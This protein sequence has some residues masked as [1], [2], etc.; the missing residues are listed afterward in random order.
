[1]LTVYWGTLVTVLKVGHYGLI[2]T[3]SLFCFSK[4]L[5][6]ETQCSV[7]GPTLCPPTAHGTEEA[8]AGLVLEAG[9]FLPTPHPPTVITDLVMSS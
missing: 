1:M 9:R 2:F 7:Q 4:G 5:N 8:E 6:Q 3:A